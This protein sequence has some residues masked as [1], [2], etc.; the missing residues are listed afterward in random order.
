MTHVKHILMM[1]LHL[2]P[3]EIIRNPLNQ[4]EQQCTLAFPF[5]PLKKAIIHS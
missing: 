2:Y 3:N 4:I 5:I 1:P